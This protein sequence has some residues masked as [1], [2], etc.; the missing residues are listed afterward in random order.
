MP[1]AISADLK[2]RIVE[3]YFTKNWSMRDIAETYMVSIGLVHKVITIFRDYGTVIDPTKSRD[4][5]PRYCTNEDTAY[6]RVLIEANPTT[7]LDEIQAKL[8]LVR[9]V[10]VAL[11]TICRTI[12]RMGITRKGVSRAAAERDEELRDLFEIRM[13]Q[14]ED[15]DLFVFLDESAVD[16]RTAQRGFGWADAGLPCV[17]RATFLRGIRYSILP[18]LTSSGIIALDIFEGSVTKERF[19]G[20]LREQVVRTPILIRDCLMTHSRRRN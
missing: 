18:A 4:G 16:R 10:H 19:I 15:P 13:A 11:A 9:N 3:L 14:Y 17:E 1:A 6:I 2:E 20:F 5:R 12:Q 8:A 7:H